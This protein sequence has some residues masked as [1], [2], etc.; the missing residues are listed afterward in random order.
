M[1]ILILSARVVEDCTSSPKAEILI[2]ASV[3]G[4]HFLDLSSMISF[5]KSGNP[6]IDP[7]IL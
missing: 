3:E 6:N 5:F 1:S 4:S 7:N 2:L